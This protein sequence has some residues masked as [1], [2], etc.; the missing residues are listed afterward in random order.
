MDLDVVNIMLNIFHL[1]ALI[2][3][4]QTYCKS[5]NGNRVVQG[6]KSVKLDIIPGK[7]FSLIADYVLFCL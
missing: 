3:G 5:C 4:I 2:C 7:S 6:S 1:L